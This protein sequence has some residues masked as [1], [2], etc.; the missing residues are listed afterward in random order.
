[1]IE[2]AN[3]E[4]SVTVE[5]LLE[6]YWEDVRALSFYAAADAGLLQGKLLGLGSRFFQ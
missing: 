1:M 4:R 3:D 5:I 2:I 6:G